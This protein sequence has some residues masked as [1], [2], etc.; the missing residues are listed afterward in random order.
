MH[1][2][3]IG[4]L[5]Y[6]NI[7]QKAILPALQN[8]SEIFTINAIA[9]RSLSIENEINNKYPSALFFSSYNNLLASNVI[10]AIYIPLP[11][12]MHY[13]WCKK[14]IQKGIHVIV[15]KSLACSYDEV[16]ELNTIAKQKNVALLENF[17][18]RKHSQLDYL[19]KCINTGEIGELRFIRS[20]FCFPPFTD[21]TNIRY[22]KIL[23]GG[24]LLDAGAYPIKIASEILGDNITLKSALLNSLGHEVDILGGGTILQDET[25]VFFQFAFGFDNYY[26]CNIEVVGTKGKI[27]TNRIFTAPPS[28]E[29]IYRHESQD[30]ICDIVLEPDN[31]Y[32]NMLKYFYQCIYND[33]LK[34]QEYIGNIK[35]AQLLDQFKKLINE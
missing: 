35:Q 16:I 25:N 15:E 18:F 9:S 27:S 8:L 12:S 3:R 20:S 29:P 4:V 6:A 17:Q 24:A 1:N 22:Q 14:A 33:D 10:D 13:E 19:K 26:Q 34:N 32:V 2:I 5:G 28:L 7:A 11:N 23:G 31:A 21:D 30:S